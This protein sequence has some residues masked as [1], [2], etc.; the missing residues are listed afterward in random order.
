VASD[1]GNV[2]EDSE[3]EEETI[4]Q[5]D[6][7]SEPEDVDDAQSPED[8]QEAVG[9]YLEN[10][11]EHLKMSTPKEMAKPADALPTKNYDE[12]MQKFKGKF[13]EHIPH[14]NSPT[15]LL[16]LFPSWSVLC[17]G[18]SSLY[19]HA[20][21]LRDQPNFKPGSEYLLPLD[22]HL[23]VVSEQWE[24]DMRQIAPQTDRNYRRNRRRLLEDAAAGT[25][26][27][28]IKLFLGLDYECPR[29][30]R[31][32]VQE[33]GKPLRHRR[34]SGPLTVS[35]A[36]LLKSDLPLWMPCTCKREPLVSA[37]LMRIHVVTPKAPIS[38]MINPRVKADANDPGHFIVGTTPIELTWAKYYV[39]RLPFCYVGPYG[40]TYPPTGSV[41]KGRFLK[42]FLSVCHV[43]LT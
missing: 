28:K 30:H 33:P 29:G 14:T 10:Y 2:E 22:L 8:E 11:D 20:N 21:G 15:D 36:P 3:E 34:G 4:K 37:Q 32:M 19:S 6:K 12:L 18:P 38:V 40:E 39:I 9:D 41:T 24:S 5:E 13:L 23:T 7:Q 17:V 27:E 35:A 25:N 16:P 42:D 43:P 26:K 31:F 1:G